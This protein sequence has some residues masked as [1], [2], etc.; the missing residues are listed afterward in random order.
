[1]TFGERLKSL[2]ERMGLTQDQL[3]EAVGKTGKAVWAWENDVNDPRMGIV[4]K[5]AIFFA[6]PKSYLM[7]EDQPSYLRA[8]LDPALGS[9]TPAANK[10]RELGDALTVPALGNPHEER[11]INIYRGLNEKG[12]DMLLNTAVSYAANPELKKD[13]ASSEETA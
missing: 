3:G 4:E 5:L 11:L 13:G 12:Q 6:V 10:L 1:M 8:A 7:G 2:R 9:D